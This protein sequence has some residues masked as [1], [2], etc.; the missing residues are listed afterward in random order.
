MNRVFSGYR[1]LYDAVCLSEPTHQKEFRQIRGKRLAVP[2]F[3]ILVVLGLAIVVVP[4]QDSELITKVQ[5]ALKEKGY[6]PGPV[7]GIMGPRTSK[8]LRDFQIK[9]D[10]PV[11]GEIDKPTLDRLG[12]KGS[13]M[14]KVGSGFKTVA[15]ATTKGAKATASATTTGA[16]ATA[17][18]AT[19]GA[20]ATASGATT[21]A[22]ATASGASKGAKATASGAT[23][24]A[25][26]TASGASKGG[27][28]VASGATKGANPHRSPIWK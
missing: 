12:I 17:K 25:K 28:A 2:L 3:C 21:G 23:T 9:N 4:A 7:D 22:K 1:T 19:K 13:F 14:G 24:G 5:S 15:G 8:A 6:N 26:A 10:I 27:K 18:G 11:S 20:K 16:K